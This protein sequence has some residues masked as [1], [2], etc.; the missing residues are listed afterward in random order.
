LNY[1]LGF[2]IERKQKTGKEANFTLSWDNH[3]LHLNDA[4]TK[5]LIDP[6]FAQKIQKLIKDSILHIKNPNRDII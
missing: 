4:T 6:N 1:S 5:I 3:D 2:K